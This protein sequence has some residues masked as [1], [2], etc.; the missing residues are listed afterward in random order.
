MI[1]R[2]AL[3]LALATAVG[4]GA[5]AL[6]VRGELAAVGDGGPVELFSVERGSTLGPVARQLE[7][8]G[9]VRNARVFVALARW[10][11]SAGALRAG[12][13]D[14]SPAWPSAEILDRL[15]RGVSKTYAVSI[16]EGLRARE[17][18]ERL[19]AAGLANAEHFL[20]VVRD[21]DFA[22]EL[23]IEAAGLEGYLFP[24]TY[25]LPRGLAVE[26]VVRV[27]VAQFE[28]EWQ[29]LAPEGAELPLP[30]HQ[31]VTL[32][33]IVE[34]ET[35]AAPER[36]LIASVFWNRLQR[37]MRLETDPT[38]IYGIADFDGNLRRVHLEDESNPYNTY[39]IPGLPPSPIANPGRAALRAVLEPAQDDY[40]YFVAR[41]D[42][43]HVFTRTLREHN[44]ANALARLAWDSIR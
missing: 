9:L 32:A 19:E 3:G 37:G 18:A 36:P 14:L 8:R 5:A 30:R 6:W 27:L 12:E 24:E 44:R 2:A 20:E 15:T 38:V 28:R 42:G 4:V 34:K 43:S 10:Q 39:R 17:V 33:S 40:L 22:R 21:P 7:E 1:L 23:G 41:P 35:G 25:R 11:E 31:L 16:P 29:K 13:Y 26:A